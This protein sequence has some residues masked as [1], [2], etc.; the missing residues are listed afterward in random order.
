LPEFNLAWNVVISLISVTV[1]V[2][3]ESKVIPS[4]LMPVSLLR[5]AVIDGAVVSGVD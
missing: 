5:L 2:I 3:V 4:V 1:P